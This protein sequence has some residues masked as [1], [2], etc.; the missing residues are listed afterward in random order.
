MESDKWDERYRAASADSAGR[1][2]SGDPHQAVQ[3]LIEALHPGRALDLATGDGRNAIFLAQR[4]WD[5]TGVDFSAEGIRLAR[6]RAHQLGA[7]VLWVVADARD[8]QPDASFDLVVATYLHLPEGEIRKVLRAAASWVAPGGHLLVLGHDKDNL[9][10]G[11][12]GPSNA[13]ILYSRE[14]L[15][16]CTAGL[17]VERS[18]QIFRDSGVDPEGPGDAAAIAVDT[19][20]IARA[21]SSY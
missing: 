19:L 13:D 6:Q 8:Y 7:Q 18:E 2:W 1:L 3:E 4:G 5:A 21:P 15:E 9:V 20:L 12:S 10:S 16:S 11:A 17:F 14:L